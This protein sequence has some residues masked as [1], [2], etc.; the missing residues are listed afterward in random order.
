MIC[1][2]EQIRPPRQT[3][4]S[5][6]LVYWPA[7]TVNISTVSDSVVYTVS[8]SVVYTVSDSVV[9]TVSDSVVYTVSDSIERTNFQEP[10]HI[11]IL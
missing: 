7:W 6:R 11:T 8:D 5:D 4:E 2:L 3:H 9:Y 1:G 10:Y